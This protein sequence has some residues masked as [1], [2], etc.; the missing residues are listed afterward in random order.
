MA[1]PSSRPGTGAIPYGSGTTFRVWAPDVP[2][3]TVAGTFNGWNDSLHEL[4]PEGGGYWSIDAEGAQPGNEYRFALKWP[5]DAPYWHMDPY[6]RQVTNSIGNSVIV[7]GE[8]D[9]GDSGFSTS[10]WNELVIYQLHA[11]TFN[12]YHP[13][14]GRPAQFDATIEA[15]PYLRDLGVNAIK[16]LPAKEFAADYSWGYNPSHIFAVESAYGGP[17]ALKRFVRAAHQNGLAVILDV[18]YNHFGPQDLGDCLWRFNGWSENDKGGIYFYNDWRSW[19]PWGEKNRPDYGRGEVRQF[20]HDNALYWLEEF[21]LDGLR[22][23]ATAYIRTVGDFGGDLPEGWSLLQWINDE[24]RA[25]Q[26]W[27]ITIAEDMRGNHAVTQRDGA[28]FGSQWDPDFVH[29]VRRVLTQPQDDW[30]DMNA[31]AGSIYHRFNGDALGRVIYT[32]SHDEVGLKNG[33]RR[34]P[35]DIDASHP[36]GY[37]AKKRSTLGAALVMTAPGIPMIFQG[38]EFMED[39]QFHDDQPLDWRKLKWFSGINLLYRDLIRLR[40][41]WFDNTRGLRGQHV[42]VQHVNHGDKVI[43]FH[44]WDVGGS[45]DD[46]I[47]VMNFAN[48]AWNDY[49]VGVPREGWWRVRFNSDS[50]LYSPDFANHPAFDTHSEQIGADGMGRSIR[51]S[52]GPYTCVILSQ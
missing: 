32:E 19:T 46:V 26:P 35:V 21:R 36:G 7:D 3:V 34:L 25:R 10:P 44:R 24:I 13:F 18:V 9:W 40:R 1:T 22:F 39:A 42:N 28:G 11:G 8:F 49:R 33:K 41:N 15:L 12:D 30:R 48:R 37:F 4:A 14:D 20:I 52:I 45:G 5:G 38:Q 51:M 29:P 2:L 47:V 16:L 31:I 50:V 27:K 43:A 23:D 17:H 6:S